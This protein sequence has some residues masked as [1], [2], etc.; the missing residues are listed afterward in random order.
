M[1]QGLWQLGVLLRYYVSLCFE[2]RKRPTLAGWW[3]SQFG[4]PEIHSFAFYYHGTHLWTIQVSKVFGDFGV[5]SFC[6]T[7]P[8]P[9]SRAAKK[10]KN[11][12]SLHWVRQPRSQ[13]VKWLG[14]TVHRNEGPNSKTIQKQT[15]QQTMNWN[16][17]ETW[18]KSGIV[19]S[20]FW[21]RWHFPILLLIGSFGAI[22][23]L[24][25]PETATCS[26]WNWQLAP[27]N[28]GP[29]GKGD[30][31]YVS[32]R[33]GIHIDFGRC[34][35]ILQEPPDSNRITYDLRRFFSRFLTM[36]LMIFLRLAESIMAEADFVFDDAPVRKQCNWCKTRLVAVN[37]QVTGLMLSYKHVG[38]PGW[39]SVIHRSFS[40][41]HICG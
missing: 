28:G 41:A 7:H 22:Q 20:S 37:A 21:K 11:R 17:P 31:D 9:P 32:F 10:Q 27:E 38:K 23:H 40:L 12:G 8:F 29:P 16:N 3:I 19:F 39:F 25:T 1:L 35:G 34:S 5:S 15:N 2:G 24:P 4:C 33:E 14:E 36:L 13:L 18:K 30:S 6:R 26:S